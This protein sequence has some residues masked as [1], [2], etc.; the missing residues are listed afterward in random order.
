MMTRVLKILGITLVGLV[1]L[2]GIVSAF[3]SP[4]SHLERSIVVNA[5]AS[6]VFEQINAFK[7][8][9][10]WSP[11]AELDPNMKITYEGPESGVGAKMNWAG[12]SDAG[13]GSQWIIESVQDKHIK[14]GLQFG[15]YDGTYSGEFNLEPAEGGT[16]VTWTYDGDVSNAGML[17]SVM[18]KFMG[19][20]MDGMLGPMYEKGLGKLKSISESAPKPT[21]SDQPS[22]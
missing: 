9:N 3:L 14:I 19:M 2:I 20:F 18:G 5:P 16:K 15:G 7:N 21:Q 6:A 8:F 22:K 13:E 12:N 1:A 17:S 10:T 11:F 4:K